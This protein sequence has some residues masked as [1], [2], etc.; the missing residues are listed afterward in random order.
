MIATTSIADAIARITLPIVLLDS[1]ID[2]FIDH[3]PDFQIRVTL[4]S[5]VMRAHALKAAADITI[6]TTFAQIIAARTDFD[7]ALDV[8]SFD[9][10]PSEEIRLFKVAMIDKAVKTRGFAIDLSPEEVL[11]RYS[12]MRLRLA[13]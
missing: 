8:L 12:A 4:N 3:S 7:A 5:E 1:M 10:I 13:S 9:E 6:A 2:D 11:A